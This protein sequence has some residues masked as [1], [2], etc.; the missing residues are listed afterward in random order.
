MWDPAVIGAVATPVV[1]ILAAL[2]TYLGVRSKSKTDVQTSLNQGFNS[3][4]EELQEE[5]KLLTD[6]RKTLVALVSEQDRKIMTLEKRVERLLAVTMS[7]H[8]FIV[9]EGLV[10]PPFDNT[11]LSNE[12]ND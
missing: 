3:L 10:P 12:N 2:F 6:E 7:F 1:A 11:L 9:N 4:I 5:R 8:N